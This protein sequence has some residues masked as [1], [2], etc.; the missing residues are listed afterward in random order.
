MIGL[1]W[2]GGLLGKIPEVVGTYFTE[3]QK[4]KSAEKMRELEL[5]D[6][7]HKRQVDLIAQGLAADATWE[8]EQIK[9]SGWKD[10]YVLIVLS[11]PLIGCFVPGLAPYIL[12]GF[13][14]LSQ[15]PQWYQ[16][17]ILLIFAAI[18]GIRVWRRQQS[19]T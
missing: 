7:I 12:R 18:Y 14:I 11:I 5:K 3:R 6:A 8:V 16:W 2:I 15:T 10:E 9:N 19:D 1:D 17:L 4:L 13:E